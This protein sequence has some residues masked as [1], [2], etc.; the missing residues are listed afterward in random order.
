MDSSAGSGASVREPGKTK[1]TNAAIERLG[2]LKTS[3][4]AIIAGPHVSHDEVSAVA[5]IYAKFSGAGGLHSS[6]D[7]SADRDRCP[8]VSKT[9]LHVAGCAVINNR[10]S[11]FKD[12]SVP[13]VN[14]SAGHERDGEAAASMPIV[15]TSTTIPRDQ[16]AQHRRIAYRC[17]L[18]ESKVRHD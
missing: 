6:A 16:L 1:G 14:N 7:A 5:S 15:V 11:S 3:G 2:T 12:S 8:H 9:A 13:L 4:L 17:V 10:P 18:F